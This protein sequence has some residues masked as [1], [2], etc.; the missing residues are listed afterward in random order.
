[1]KTLVTAAM[2]S[3]LVLTGRSLAGKY[4][5]SFYPPHQEVVALANTVWSGSENLSG[6]GQLSFEFL[7]NGKVLMSD[8]LTPKRGKVNGTYVQQGAQVTVQ[9]KDAVYVGTINGQGMSGSAKMGN[10]SW[11]FSLSRGNVPAVGAPVPPPPPSAPIAAPEFNFSGTWVAQVNQGRVYLRI[12]GNQISLNAVDANGNSGLAIQGT[13][14]LNNGIVTIYT[15]G[16]AEQMNLTVI[17]VNQIVLS[18]NQV[19]LNFN[20]QF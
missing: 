1:M 17:N 16:R 10:Q 13:F 2:L 19:R 15:N 11:A 7:P 4:D 14:T 20:R 8:A 9:F 3:L 6:Y 5:Q 12:N 18:D